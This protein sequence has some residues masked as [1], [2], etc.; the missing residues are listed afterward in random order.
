MPASNP[1]RLP[2][3]SGLLLLLLA[4]AVARAQSLHAAGTADERVVVV[5]LVEALDVPEASAMV[6]RRSAH[7]PGD[8]ILVTTDTR[9][10]DLA[11]AFGMLQ[12]SRRQMGPTVQHELRAPITPAVAVPR[13]GRAVAVSARLLTD[14]QTA[15]EALI[16][17][18]GTLPVVTAVTV[19]PEPGS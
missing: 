18:L 10:P 13:D 3:L 15:E 1:F 6:I 17:G 14:L 19:L 5:A 16:D 9:P 7:Q 8:V 2:I 4:P 11:K 12:R